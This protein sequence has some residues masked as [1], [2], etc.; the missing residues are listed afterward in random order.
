[1]N[2][3]KALFED[4]PQPEGQPLFENAADLAR[5]LIEWGLYSDKGKERSLASQLA[6]IVAVDRKCPDPLKQA[7]L[8]AVAKR[9]EETPEV[10]RQMW[11]ERVER[12]IRLDEVARQGT[13]MSA[14]ELYDRLLE[15][16]ETASLQFIVTA[17]PSEDVPSPKAGALT[18]ILLRRTGLLQLVLDRDRKVL[19]SVLSGE[20]KVTYMFNFPTAQHGQEWWRSLYVRVVGDAM[21]KWGPDFDTVE[22]EDALHRLQER[23]RIQVQVA[24]ALMCTCPLVVFEPHQAESTGFVLFYHQTGERTQVSLALMDAQA[25]GLWKKFVWDQVV[26]GGVILETVPYPRRP[27]KAEV[28]NDGN[29]RGRHRTGNRRNAP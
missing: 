14:E 3:R 18:R 5:R 22:I 2:T 23:K 25:L 1:M 17:R 15:H 10:L 21:E 8:D 7:V 19:D 20:T 16:T 27:R 4:P 29:K 13:P 6:Q 24:P 26:E 11:V 12:S 9:L 28:K